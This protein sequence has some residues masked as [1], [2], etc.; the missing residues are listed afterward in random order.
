MPET[1]IGA[2]ILGMFAAV[3]ICRDEGYDPRDLLELVN[4]D[5]RVEAIIG[6]NPYRE[7]KA[8]PQQIPQT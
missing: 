6:R 3:Q 5:E 1:R 7:G 8:P 4:D 2:A